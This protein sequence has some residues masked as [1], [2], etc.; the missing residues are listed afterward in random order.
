MLRRAGKRTRAC[1]WARDI[2]ASMG[3]TKKP[4]PQQLEGRVLSGLPLVET[5]RVPGF[6]FEPLDDELFALGYPHLALLHED[7]EDPIRAAEKLVVDGYPYRQVVFPKRA[8][9]GL[10]RAHGDRK[11]RTLLP[12]GKAE[13]AEGA[14]EAIR[15]TAELSLAEAADLVRTGVRVGRCRGARRDPARLRGSRLAPR[16]S[17]RRSALRRGAS[18]PR[19]GRRRAESGRRLPLVQLARS[20]ARGLQ[21]RPRAARRIGR[22]PRVAARARFPLLMSA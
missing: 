4:R 3:K 2:R 14:A 17:S 6:A 20:A 22:S 1:H 13:V 7:E 10:L 5:A 9:V 16:R 15:N 11:P 8:A 21:G 18:Q 12:S 19:R